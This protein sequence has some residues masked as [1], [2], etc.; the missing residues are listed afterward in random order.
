MDY[1]Q[2]MEI[3]R[4]EYWSGW[5]SSSQRVFPTQG[6]NPGLPHC[7][8]ILYQLGHKGSPKI[9]EWVAYPFSNGSSRSRN[10][11]GV[12]C[13]AGGF[14]MREAQEHKV[15]LNCSR[16]KTNI[17]SSVALGKVI[18]YSKPYFLY[19]KKIDYRI[20]YCIGL[21]CVD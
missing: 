7:R 16:F 13:I 14:C 6:S 20:I 15:H 10:R 2:S 19:L 1:I 4:P 17:S 11:T 9:L 12:S 18:R 3:S 8:Q 21:Q 5:P